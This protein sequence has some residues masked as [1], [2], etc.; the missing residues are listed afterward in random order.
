[1]V[2]RYTKSVL[3]VIAAALCVLALQNAIG[4][5]G[6]VGEI[7][8]GSSWNACHVIVEYGNLQVDGSVRIDGGHVQV[9]GSVHTY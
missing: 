2:D 7:C 5:A 6:A 3:T 9:S 4:S 1:M 8:G